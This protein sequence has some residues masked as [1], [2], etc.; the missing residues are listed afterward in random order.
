MIRQSTRA[1]G[2]MFK[3]ARPMMARPVL[4][5]KSDDKPVKTE[6]PK[7]VIPDKIV[8]VANKLEKTLEKEI[9]YEKENL[10]KDDETIKALKEKGWEVSNEGSLY[11]LKK[12]A[13]DKEVLITFTVRSPPQEKEA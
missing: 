12:K 6:K 7:S 1:L 4:C 13:G 8:D 11:E 9:T 10:P 3:M 5:F 2:K